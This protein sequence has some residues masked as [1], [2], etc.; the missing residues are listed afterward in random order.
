MKAVADVMKVYSRL[1]VSVVS[2]DGLH[3]CPRGFTTVCS[4]A[5]YMQEIS[6]PCCR[7]DEPMVILD[8]HADWRFAKNVR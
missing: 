2:S 8:T 1:G 7:G 3:M 6:L 5:C 4:G